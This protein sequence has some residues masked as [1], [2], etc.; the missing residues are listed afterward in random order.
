M[1]CNLQVH[2]LV[3]SFRAWL[4]VSLL[5]ARQN[6]HD[7]WK[8]KTNLTNTFSIVTHKRQPAAPNQFWLTAANA[9]SLS[10]AGARY[11]GM[12]TSQTSRLMPLSGMP[13]IR[14]YALV[15]YQNKCSD[16]GVKGN[17]FCLFAPFVGLNIICSLMS[18]RTRS[19]ILFVVNYG[20]IKGKRK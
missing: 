11:N 4:A 7:M 10:S 3:K 5:I 8:D 17:R 6:N 13:V 18:E 16:C 15:W 20:P 14:R 9:R 1:V 12:E 2:I 19:V